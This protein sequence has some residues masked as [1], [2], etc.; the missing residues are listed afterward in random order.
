MGFFRWCSVYANPARV[1]SGLVRDN[2]AEN[3]TVS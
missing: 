1:E 3:S 2:G